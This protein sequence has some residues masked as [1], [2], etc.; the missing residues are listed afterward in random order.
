M[1]LE[2][3]VPELWHGQILA[4]LETEAVYPNVCT[5][6][7][8]GTISQAGDIVRI[9]EIGAIN[10]NTYNSTSTGA[11]TIQQLSG[12]QKELKINQSKYTAYWLDDEDMAQISPKVQVAAM[13]GTGD[14]LAKN[15]DEYIAAL[16]TD[17]GLAIGGTSAA[18]V[19]VTSTNVLKYMSLAQQKL[20]EANTPMNGRWIVV[21]PWFAQKLTLA[22]VTLDTNN[23]ETLGKGYFGTTIYGFNVWVSNNVVHQSGTDRASI[24]CGYQGSIALAQQLKKILQERSATIGFK[25]AVK[26]LLIYG[27]K[28]IRPNNL[29][30]LFADYTAEAT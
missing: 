28:V 30:V 13:Q 23:S 11:L 6:E 29:G 19:D 10:V 2:Q 27:A 15:V 20:D 25:S 12:A 7:Y 4:R 18:G 26:A 5:R 21:P 9:N 3:F 1:A 8:E 17:A 22:K 14:A 16:W 24:M